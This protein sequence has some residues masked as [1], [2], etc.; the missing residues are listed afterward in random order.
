MFLLL[1]MLFAEPFEGLTLITSMGGGQNSSDTYLFDNDGNAINSWSHNTGSASVGYLSRDSI[2]FLPSKLVL[3]I[4]LRQI[5]TACGM[6]DRSIRW[7]GG[8]GTILTKPRYRA[9][10]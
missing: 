4:Q 2:L 3:I 5:I 10:N 1:H 9:V 7:G 8:T 6:H